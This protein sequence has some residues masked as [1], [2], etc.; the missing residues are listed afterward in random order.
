MKNNQIIYIKVQLAIIILE[1]ADCFFYF[2][3]NEG[4]LRAL[5][6]LFYLDLLV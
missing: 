6:H 2:M 3:G 1:R 4:I 5:I